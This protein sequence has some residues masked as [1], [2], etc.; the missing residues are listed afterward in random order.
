MRSTDSHR[1]AGLAADQLPDCCQRTWPILSGG[2]PRRPGAVSRP[3]PAAPGAPIDEDRAG[4]TGR[5]GA[6]PRRKKLAAVVAGH[7]PVVVA[8][9]PRGR[10]A[11]ESGSMLVTIWEQSTSHA[12][13]RSRSAL[14][15]R[16]YSDWRA[17]HPRRCWHSCS[18]ATSAA[19]S[20]RQ[21]R[22]PCRS[23]RQ[24]WRFVDASVGAGL[25]QRYRRTPADS[26][27]PPG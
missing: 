5:G 8:N 9:V 11:Q 10:H 26:S 24:A 22:Q 16:T 2:R 21:Q 12:C 27:R 7:G 4:L 15:S 23:H 17:A 3:E 18:A 6:V 20:A 25:R 19:G 14:G 13:M 1:H